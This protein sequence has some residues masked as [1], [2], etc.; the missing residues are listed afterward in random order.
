MLAI[1]ICFQENQKGN[2]S[3]DRNRDFRSAFAVTLVREG[4]GVTRAGT[5][6]TT[7]T[8][9]FEDMFGGSANWIC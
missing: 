5:A 7:R 8:G 9:R 1:V 4:G 3:E 6:T 2:G